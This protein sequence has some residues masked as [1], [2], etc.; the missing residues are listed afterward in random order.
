LTKYVR[1]W[2]ASPVPKTT[3]QAFAVCQAEALDFKSLGGPVE[4][5]SRIG[6]LRRTI[7]PS[8]LDEKYPW[9]LGHRTISSLTIDMVK[10]FQAFAI[11]GS[12]ICQAL[13]TLS[14]NCNWRAF[15]KGA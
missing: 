8:W 7:N 6:W 1:P 4:T 5:E 9:L 14:C 3:N 11:S 2:N 12:A 15:T 13:R 10:P